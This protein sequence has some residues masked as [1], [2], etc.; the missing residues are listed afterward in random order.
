MRRSCSAFN[1][2]ASLT[3]ALMPPACPSTT[4]VCAASS[5]SVRTEADSR[6]FPFIRIYYITTNFVVV[7]SYV[8]RGFNLHRADVSLRR[9]RAPSRQAGQVASAMVIPVRLA[10][11]RPVSPTHM[12]LDMARPEALGQ[13]SAALQS[14][15]KAHPLAPSGRSSGPQPVV[16]PFSVVD[17]LYIHAAD[18]PFIVCWSKAYSA[19]FTRLRSEV[20][21]L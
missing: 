4:A 16:Q 1:R 13:A 9:W 7:H 10:Q 17:G 5:S 2:R 8:S 18:T 14:D 15:P 19:A 11:R 12:Q 6:C 3:Q 21:V 20:R